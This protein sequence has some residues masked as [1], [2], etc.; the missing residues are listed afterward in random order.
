MGRKSK[1]EEVTS[2]ISRN[3]NPGHEKEYDECLRRYLEFERNAPGYLGTTIILPGGGR[4][5]LRYIIHRFM[6]RAHMDAWE[7]SQEAL[8][9]LNEVNRY[10][11]RHYE[12]ATGLETW[13]TLPDLKRTLLTPPRWKMAIVVFF[14]AYVISSIVRSIL[15]PF[16]GHLHILALGAIYSGL[17]VVMLTYLAMPLMTRLLRRWL[18]PEE[19]RYRIPSEKTGLVCHQI[20]I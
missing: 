10:S 11:T 1:N 9:L 7:N 8:N 19:V 16:L 17:L 5:N 4:S 20:T 15:D 12:D 3:I 13:F 18:Y 6:D 14:T 2:V